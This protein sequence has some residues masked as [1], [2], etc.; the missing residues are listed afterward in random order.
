MVAR[1]FVL[2]RLHQF[3]RPPDFI[4]M[5]FDEDEGRLRAKSQ[6]FGATTL[7]ALATVVAVVAAACLLAPMGWA[8]A[9]GV[10]LSS[11]FI[12]AS[13]NDTRGASVQYQYEV[14]GHT[15]INDRLSL[16]R[17]AGKYDAGSGQWM[18]DD[19][20]LV[21]EHPQGSAI[22]VFYDPG[23]PSRSVVVAHANMPGLWGAGAVLSV[24]WVIAG[25]MCWKLRRG[26]ESGSHCD[27]SFHRRAA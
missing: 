19:R 9:Q 27:A 24:M 4:C 8:R 10:V 21:N 5:N 16:F 1:G 18:W 20:R 17:S 12:N 26:A 3:G 7:A 15:Y 13:G 2:R 6:A 22:E 23:T 25:N 11:A 14:D